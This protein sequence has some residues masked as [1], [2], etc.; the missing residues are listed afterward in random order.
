MTRSVAPCVVAWTTA[1]WREADF[2]VR[3]AFR[4]ETSGYICNVL[5]HFCFALHAVDNAND[6]FSSA[7]PVVANPGSRPSTP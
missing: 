4:R 6:T 7:E 2:F 3:A 1:H 5:T